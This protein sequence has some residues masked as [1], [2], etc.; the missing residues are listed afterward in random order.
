M[1]LIDSCITQL[2]VQGPSRTC[3][4]SKEE[5]EVN[6]AEQGDERALPDP[7]QLLSRKVQRFRGGLVFKAGR[8][9]YH[10]TL[11]SRV[12]K[13]TTCDEGAAGEA[14]VVRHSVQQL[15][16]HMQTINHKLGSN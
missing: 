10:S 6:L 13:Q 5:E 9:V 3:N 16:S 1:R 11:G 2:K 14:A 4:E 12:I 7:E 15:G 8:L